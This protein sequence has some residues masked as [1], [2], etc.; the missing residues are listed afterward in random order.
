MYMSQAV[1]GVPK[2]NALASHPQDGSEAV[3]KPI[4]NLEGK[5]LGFWLTFGEY[6]PYRKIGLAQIN[7]QN[8]PA[9]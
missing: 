1:F 8:L 7:K 2:L 9:S 3:R 4:E 5:V 6:G